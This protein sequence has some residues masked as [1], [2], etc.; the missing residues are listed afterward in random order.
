MDT[1]FGH[2]YPKIQ[3]IAR[4]PALEAL[5]GVLPQIHGK[6]SAARRGR[7]VHRARPAQLIRRG[8]VAN[9]TEQGQNLRYRNH[10]ANRSEINTRHGE[11]LAQGDAAAEQ[12]RGTRT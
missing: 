2:G 11:H 1:L 6:R 7:A 4:G 5:E 10:G 8:A 12:G 3:L 9:K